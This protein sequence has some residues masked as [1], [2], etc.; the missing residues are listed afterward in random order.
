VGVIASPEEGGFWG[1]RGARGL[2][3]ASSAS[4]A[5]S[6]ASSWADG[7]WVGLRRGW[8]AAAAEGRELAEA[9]AR[10]ML[11]SDTLGSPNAAIRGRR[12]ARWY[13]PGAAAERTTAGG[14]VGW[15]ASAGG[16]SCGRS[17]VRPRA[18]AKLS[19]AERVSVRWPGDESPGCA[20]AG[21]SGGSR[22]KSRGLTSKCP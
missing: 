11:T 21:C 22:G 8:D 10:V 4:I 9:A 19:K 3:L 5:R 15:A 1:V 2:M 6:S 17:T 14:A 20:A 16:I 12:S 7:R 13:E 18:W